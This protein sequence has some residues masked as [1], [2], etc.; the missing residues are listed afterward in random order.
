MPMRLGILS[1]FLWSQSIL[2]F[3]QASRYKPYP[4]DI[5]PLKKQPALGAEFERYHLKFQKEPL[6]PAEHEKRMEVVKK[7][8]EKSPEWL[9][10]YWLYAADTFFIGS[11][12]QDPKDHP[13]ARA[14]LG[15]GLNSINECLRRKPDHVLCK[16]F[17][18]SFQAKIASIDGVFSSLRH[19]KKIRDTWIEVTEGSY[20]L[21]FRPNVSMQGTTRFALGMFYRLIPDFFMLDWIFG[22]RGNINKSIQYHRDAQKLD[23]QNPCVHLMLA[24]S[25]LCKVKGDV[26]AEPYQE[27]MKLLDRTEREK[28]IDLAQAVCIRD[29]EKIRK[30]PSKTCGYTQAKYQDE[31]KESDI[32]K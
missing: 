24:V 9:D 1:I 5:E 7:V 27:S 2:G 3:G 31:V 6:E 30:E 12:Y 8:L 20:D 14:I 26:K 23:P 19:A 29:V 18:A 32:P 25:L 28:P 4:V 13:K 10:G 22:V 16:F 11:N 15:K 21:E 17:E